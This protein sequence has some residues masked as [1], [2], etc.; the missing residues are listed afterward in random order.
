MENL[1][2]S[3]RAALDLAGES[4]LPQLLNRRYERL[5]SYGKFKETRRA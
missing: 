5:M 3:L 1:R 4:S 2:Q